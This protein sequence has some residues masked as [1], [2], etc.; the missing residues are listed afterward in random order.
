MSGGADGDGGGVL[1]IGEQGRDGGVTEWEG[2]SPTEA[3][4]RAW[5]RDPL[6]R[7][8]RQTPKRVSAPCGQV[9]AEDSD[10][11]GKFQR[12]RDKVSVPG[13]SVTI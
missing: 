12:S 4:I 10:S 1:A 2:R 13:P 3:R 9:A 6:A 8:G 7:S 5:P 11:S